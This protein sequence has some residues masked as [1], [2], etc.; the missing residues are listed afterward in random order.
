[1][2]I[3]GCCLIIVLI[4][5]AVGGYLYYKGKQVAS[6]AGSSFEAEM[7]RISLSVTLD[8]IISACGA[9][10]SGNAAAA[11]F[12]PAVAASYGPLACQANADTVA[13]FSDANRST[14]NALAGSPDEGLATAQGLDPNSC[15]VYTSGAA[16]VIGCSGADG[17][18]LLHVEAL[19]QVQP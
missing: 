14:A 13:A 10:P 17:F 11:Y 12:N 5:C 3:G 2:I 16:K 1:M 6:E 7:N 15:F 9:D 19:D 8:G 18:K 4:S